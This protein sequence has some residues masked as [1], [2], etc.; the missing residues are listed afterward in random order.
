MFGLLSIT[1][2]WISSVM[3]T[4]V[5]PV[6]SEKETSDC[7]AP[8]FRDDGDGLLSKAAQ[9]QRALSY[10]PHA[11]PQ[12]QTRATE[13]PNNSGVPC[14]TMHICFFIPLYDITPSIA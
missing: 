13:P 1:V 2:V 14:P 11:M 9:V 5:T 7:S 4:V 10:L 12:R 6:P 8:P 3:T